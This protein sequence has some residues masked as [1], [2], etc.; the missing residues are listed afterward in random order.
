MTYLDSWETGYADGQNGRPSQRRV[1]LDSFSYSSGYLQGRA[2]E[3][4]HPQS[5]RGQAAQRRGAGS[6][7]II[8]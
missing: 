7:L 1:D 3:P 8:L 6:R 2:Q 4:R 5:S